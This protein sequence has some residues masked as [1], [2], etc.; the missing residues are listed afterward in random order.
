[1]LDFERYKGGEI[2]IPNT[3]ANLMVSSLSRASG[4]INPVLASPQ[5]TPALL[6]FKNSLLFLV[7]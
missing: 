3:A 4:S 5:M 2:Y 7:S 1:M 6:N